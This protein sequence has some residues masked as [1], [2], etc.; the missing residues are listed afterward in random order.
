VN[1]YSLDIGRRRHAVV[2]DT[3]AKAFE[4]AA[5]EIGELATTGYSENDMVLCD[6]DEPLAIIVDSDG[7]ISDTGCEKTLAMREWARREGPGYLC[8]G[9]LEPEVLH[10]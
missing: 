1:V 9:E 5:H 6:P 10:D 8:T 2:A 4:F 7:D 3:P